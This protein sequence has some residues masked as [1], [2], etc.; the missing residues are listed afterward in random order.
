WGGLTSKLDGLPGSGPPG[1][2]TSWPRRGNMRSLC[3]TA[4]VVRFLEIIKKNANFASAAESLPFSH[5]RQEG[6]RRHC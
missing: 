1:Q 3:I 6:A 4:K 2:R 5:Q